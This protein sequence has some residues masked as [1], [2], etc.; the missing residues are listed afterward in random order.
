V[1]NLDVVPLA[2][3]QIS[4]IRNEPTW[5]LFFNLKIDFLNLSRHGTAFICN[6]REHWFT[7]R[8]LGHQWFNLNSLLSGAQPTSDWPTVHIYEQELTQR[9]FNVCEKIANDSD[10]KWNEW[11][12]TLLLKCSNELSL[13]IFQIGC[14]AVKLKVVCC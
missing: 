8:K 2:N 6:L 1:W 10:I 9:I 13:W 7:V 3:P 12:I 4:Y 14:F 5:V 11:C